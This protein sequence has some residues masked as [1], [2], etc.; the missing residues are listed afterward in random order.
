MKEGISAAL[1]QS[2]LNESWWADLWNVTLICETSQIYYLM[3]RRLVK[4]VFG[5]PFE[6]TDFSISFIG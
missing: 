4:D 5:Q 2:G 6:G 1:L 3:G